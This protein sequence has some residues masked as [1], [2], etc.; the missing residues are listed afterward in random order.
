MYQTRGQGFKKSLAL[1][2]LNTGIKKQT[3]FFATHEGPE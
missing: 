3:F 1:Q 2:L